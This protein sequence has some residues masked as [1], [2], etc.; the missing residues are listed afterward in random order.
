MGRALPTPQ[1]RHGYPHKQWAFLTTMEGVQE[2][3]ECG[4]RQPQSRWYI[5]PTPLD[6]TCMFWTFRL[7]VEVWRAMS[8]LAAYPPSAEPLMLDATDARPCLK[9]DK[10]G[11]ASTI[12]PN[13]HLHA[14]AQLLRLQTVNALAGC[15][16][17]VSPL[18][19]LSLRDEVL[20][21]MGVSLDDATQAAERD[22]RWTRYLGELAKPSGWGGHREL[23]VLARVLRVSVEVYDYEGEDA[24]G[25]D[26][27]RIVLHHTIPQRTDAD[28]DHMTL[29]V[30]RVPHPPP[31]HDAMHTT[32]LRV[33][34]SRRLNHYMLLL[35]AAE[36]SALFTRYGFAGTHVVMAAWEAG[37]PRFLNDPR[38]RAQY[39]SKMA[40]LER[41]LLH[42]DGEAAETE[43]AVAE[44]AVN[45]TTALGSGA[46]AADGTVAAEDQV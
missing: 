1:P 25:T 24:D 6:G 33:L 36:Y 9:L 28:A 42:P 22:V 38:L 31:H 27:G 26:D 45:A 21:S 8:T 14:G 12:V 29:A 43:A 18:S 4:A 15:A 30:S 20:L 23:A 17:E 35:T 41:M 40:A 11:A 19:G 16:N 5:V 32:T 3:A 46:G 39:P 10:R 34:F 44:G 7:G 2:A 37:T 13:E